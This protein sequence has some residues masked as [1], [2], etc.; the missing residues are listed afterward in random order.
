[1]LQYGWFKDSVF[2]QDATDS[3]YAAVE[4]GLYWV[5]ATSASGCNAVA[6]PVSVT[7]LPSPPVPVVNFN[8]TNQV[9]A[10][11]ASNFSIRWFLNGDEIAGANSHILTVTETGMYSAEYSNT[12]GCRSLSQELAVTNIISGLGEIPGAIVSLFPNPSS[13]GRFNLTLRD[14]GSGGT[15]SITDAAGREVYQKHLHPDFM[16]ADIDL[17][18]EPAGIY[19]CRIMTEKGM[20]VEKIL[21]LK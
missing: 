2:Q 19:L 18:H 3:F 21:I 6:E 1:M 20:A 5:E 8:G 11:N 17:T 7:V 10:S 12:S 16:N 15:I 4:T 9:Y 14:A 13:D